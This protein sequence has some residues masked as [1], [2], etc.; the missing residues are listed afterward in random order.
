M[1]VMDDWLLV[2]AAGAELDDAEH[3]LDDLARRAMDSDRSSQ[4]WA[5]ALQA[6]R[7]LRRL[8]RLGCPRL[9]DDPGASGRSI[10]VLL[11]PMVT[12]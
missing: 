7:A 3:L 6:L 12:P 10:A 5:R 1:T 8:H 9:P 2:S 11:D 4:P